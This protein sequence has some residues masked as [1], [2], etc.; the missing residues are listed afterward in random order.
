MIDQKDISK[1]TDGELAAFAAKAPPGLS[2]VI[3]SDGGF[4]F[5]ADRVIDGMSRTERAELTIVRRAH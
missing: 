1:M 4:G 2:P 3:F 5:L